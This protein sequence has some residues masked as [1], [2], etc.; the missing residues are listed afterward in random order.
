M[1][2]INFRLELFDEAGLGAETIK[3]LKLVIFAVAFGTISFNINGGVSMTGYLK[4][5]G[6]D[7]FTFGLLCAIGPLAAPMQL[8]ASYILERTRKRRTLFLACGIIQRMS[9][10]PFGC[11]PFFIPMSPYGLRI[12]MASL[13][14][15]I[16]A[17]LVPFVN[18][19]FFSLAADLVPMNIRGSYFAVRSRITT[20]FGVAGGILTAWFLDTFSGFSSY[21]FVFALSAAMGTLDILCFLQVKFPPMAGPA[22]G[23][24]EKFSKMASD[25]LKNKKYMKFALFMTLWFFSCSLSTPFY[26]VYLRNTLFFSNTLITVLVQILPNVCSIL[27]VKRWGQAIDA[28]GNKAVMQMTNGILCVAPFLWIFTSNSAASGVLIVLIMLL[29]GCLFSGFDIG[30]NNIMLGHAPPLN[31]SMYIAFY[32]TMTQMVGV[33]L[34][35]AAGGWLLDNVFSVLEQMDIVLLGAKM[36]RYNYIF[37]LTAILRF[38]VVY[39][40]L[41]RM[42]SEQGS[43]SAGEL[44]A[45]LLLDR[46]KR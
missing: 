22:P 5:L 11:V 38:A 36:T 2:K 45:K 12:W 6:A 14:L 17:L 25:V 10:L 9:W 20:M 33:G 31:R 44:L 23:G 32:F 19:S 3:S 8:L 7:D 26:L 30:A 40:A 37:A 15:M 4:E 41:P 28:H 35:N 29:Q 16:S 27:I 42:I 34:G 18:V 46:K 39:L 43:A 24:G 13:F 21:A 1:K